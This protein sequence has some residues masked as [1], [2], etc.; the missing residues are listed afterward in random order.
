[1]SVCVRGQRWSSVQNY[2]I[3]Q[4]HFSSKIEAVNLCGQKRC[5]GKNMAGRGPKVAAVLAIAII[6]IF[7]A[8]S[9]SAETAE[10]SVELMHETVINRC[11]GLLKSPIIVPRGD[12]DVVSCIRNPSGYDGRTKKDTVE[13]VSALE[14]TNLSL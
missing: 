10:V 12:A 8:N 14:I 3:E 9:T 6:G 7:T 1:M 5:S 11:W 2:V 13:K 4:L